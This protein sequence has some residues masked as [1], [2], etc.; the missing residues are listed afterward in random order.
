MCNLSC[1]LNRSRRKLRMRILQASVELLEQRT[2]HLEK[3]LATAIFPNAE[4]IERLSQ[5]VGKDIMIQ[6]NSIKIPGNLLAVYSDSFKLRDKKGQLVIIPASKVIS[7]AFDN[8]QLQ[9]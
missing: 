7:I 8:T 2:D 1:L 6:T 5:S 9:R 4:T 3:L